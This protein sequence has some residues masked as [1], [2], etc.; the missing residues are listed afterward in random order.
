LHPSS[1]QL[2]D[3]YRTSAHPFHG[4]PFEKVRDALSRWFVVERVRVAEA[5]FLQSARSRVRVTVTP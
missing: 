4:Q 5:A 3:V 1:E 2:R